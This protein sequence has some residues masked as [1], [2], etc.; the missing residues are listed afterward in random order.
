MTNTIGCPGL[1]SSKYQSFLMASVALFSVTG[2]EK[3]IRRESNNFLSMT[4]C[5]LC[6]ISPSGIESPTKLAFPDRF[7]DKEGI[8]LINQPHV[9]SLPERS[10]L[11]ALPHFY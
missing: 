11:T 9:V 1:V 5:N 7:Q 8:F 4:S 2:S 3:K 10:L 6:I